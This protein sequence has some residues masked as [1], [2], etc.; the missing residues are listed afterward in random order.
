MAIVVD[1]LI[2]FLLLANE[3]WRRV[4]S[5]SGKLDRHES[6]YILFVHDWFRK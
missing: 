4:L 2:A 5:S 1:S 6:I 3:I